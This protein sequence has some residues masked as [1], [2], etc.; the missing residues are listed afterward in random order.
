MY[1]K[2]NGHE[3]IILEVSKEHI[4]KIYEEK[5]QDKALYV[6]GLTKFDNHKIYINSE[7]CHDMKRKTLMHELMHCY[8]EEYISLSLEEYD[9]ETM[10]NISANSHDIIH[11]IVDTYFNKEITLDIEC[12][13]QGNKIYENMMKK[14]IKE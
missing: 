10:C 8:I 13:I 2:I 7:L 14:G 3:W 5:M 4:E 6:Y 9:E 12:N 1:F 11:E